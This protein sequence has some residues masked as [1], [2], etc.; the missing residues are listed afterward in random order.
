MREKENHTTI[1]FNTIPTGYFTGT[2]VYNRNSNRY[3]GLFLAVN[4]YVV[5]VDAPHMSWSINSN[6]LC[7]NYQPV[8]VEVLIK[9]N[10]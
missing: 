3:I 9:E 8:R 1:S 6:A 2:I 4:E 5:A 10:L 7:E